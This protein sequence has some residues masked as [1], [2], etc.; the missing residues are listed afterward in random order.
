MTPAETALARHSLEELYDEERAQAWL[1]KPHILLGNKN[2]LEASFLEV[3]ALIEQIK[4][5]F[6]I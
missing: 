1:E 2:P 4:T 6:L 3:L 5:G